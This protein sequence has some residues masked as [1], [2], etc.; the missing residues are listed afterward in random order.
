ME[1]INTAAMTYINLVITAEF[2]FTMKIRSQFT[3]H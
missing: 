2:V 3:E 1:P